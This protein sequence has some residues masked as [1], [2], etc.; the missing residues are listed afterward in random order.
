VRD[1][2]YN[3][4]ANLAANLLAL[5]IISFIP[6]VL[7]L[8]NQ[9]VSA[10]DPVTFNWFLGIGWTTNL[11][12][13]IVWFVDHRKW[14]ARRT[15]LLARLMS[16]TD[17]PVNKFILSEFGPLHGPLAHPE[18]RL[19]IHQILNLMCQILAYRSSID[20]KGATLLILRDSRFELYAEVGHR[21]GLEIDVNSNLT[22]ENSLAGQALGKDRV[23]V[24]PDCRKTTL[25]IRWKNLNRRSEFIGRAVVPVQALIRN[26]PKTAQDIGVICFDLKK[27]MHLT[28]DEQEI[29]LR[30]ADKVA[31]LLVLHQE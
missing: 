12:L 31:A 6:A 17:G 5:W 11:I 7:V 19:Q 10:V 27:R 13:G 15:S 25:G 2:I 16:I 24:L 29:M 8:L 26:D 30:V 21:P 20:D 23:V 3:I 14:H 28:P 9:T 22:K 4:L 18:I 1:F